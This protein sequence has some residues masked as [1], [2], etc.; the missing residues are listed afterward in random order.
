MQPSSLVSLPVPCIDCSGRRLEE[1]SSGHGLSTLGFHL[2]H[3]TGLLSSLKIPPH[4]AARL[5]SAM[6][7]AY[8]EQ[9]Y[10]N[11][12]H[13]ADVM[14]TMHVLL[15]RSGMIGSYTEPLT[16]LAC[17][18][19]AAGEGRALAPPTAAAHPDINSCT[20]A[21]YATGHDLDHG[22]ALLFT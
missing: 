2:L 3:T 5:L 18:L 8:Q 12:T 9:P 7:S 10:H 16:H 19:A 4:R 6:E 20:T 17:L 21:A 15:Q 1:L 11:K 14:Q 13:A 22:G